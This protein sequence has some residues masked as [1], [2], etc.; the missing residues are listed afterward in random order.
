MKTAFLSLVAAA[1]LA[2][3]AGSADARPPG[4]PL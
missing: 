1:A 2:V 3:S 4:V